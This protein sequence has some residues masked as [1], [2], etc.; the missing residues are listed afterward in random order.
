MGSKT[1]EDLDY[2]STLYLYYDN[3]KPSTIKLEPIELYITDDS[4]SE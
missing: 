4:Y 2:V 3:Y 1:Y